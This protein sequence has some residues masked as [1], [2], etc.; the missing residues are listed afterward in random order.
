MVVLAK[1]KQT[2]TLSLLRGTF[3]NQKQCQILTLNSS[4]KPLNQA[5]SSTSH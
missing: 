3:P 1:P 2:E 4:S 5:G